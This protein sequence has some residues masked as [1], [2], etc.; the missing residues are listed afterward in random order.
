M[1]LYAAIDPGREPLDDD[2]IEQDNINIKYEGY[3]K[4]TASAGR[5][6]QEN[7]KQTNS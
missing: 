6:V 7:G 5:T 3:I 1:N 2:V 4:E